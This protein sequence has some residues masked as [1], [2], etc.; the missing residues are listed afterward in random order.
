[1][2][3][4][5]WFRDICE[6][7]NM[8]FEENSNIKIPDFEEKNSKWKILTNEIRIFLCKCYH[9]DTPMQ[10]WLPT[11]N[12]TIW[13]KP[14]LITIKDWKIYYP[15]RNLTCFESFRRVFKLILL[16]LIRIQNRAIRL[17]LSVIR[18]ARIWKPHQGK[19]GKWVRRSKV[20]IVS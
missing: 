19:L 3:L 11:D 17:A 7:E 5:I 12:F 1:M 16:N 2:G 10:K 18:W 4:K 20:E 14:I 6:N 8:N 13:A 9:V 15:N